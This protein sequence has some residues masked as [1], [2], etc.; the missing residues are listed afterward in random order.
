MT[1][2]ETFIDNMRFYRRKAGFSQMKLA[3]LCDISPN[4]VGEIE[5]GRKFP[6]IDAIERIAAALTIEPYR[7]FQDRAKADEDFTT[8][9]ALAMAI[10]Q[11]LDDKARQNLAEKFL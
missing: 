6:S 2:R 8:A 7:L 10:V 9:Y 5:I 3:E 11:G 1:L 4:Y